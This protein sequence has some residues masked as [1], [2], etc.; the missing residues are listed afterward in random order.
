MGIDIFNQINNA[1]L[2][3][4]R[5]E[6]QTYHQ[7]IKR[8]ARLLESDELANA[9][10]RLLPKADFDEFLKS[11]QPQGGMLGSDSLDW[12]EDPEEILSLQLQM[13][14]RFGA[15][16]DYMR[17]FGHE[18]Y[19]SNR[20]VGSIRSITSQVIIPFARDFK[21]F[22]IN[23]FSTDGRLTLPTSN[24]V[25]VVHGHDEAALQG[26]AR[27]IEKI[28]LEAIVLKEQPNQGRTVIEKFEQASADVG[29]AVILLTP[30]DIGSKVTATEQDKRAR[31]NVIYELGYFTGKLGRGRVCLLMKGAV[32]IPSDL[33]GVIYTDLDPAEG[34]KQRLV[35][36]MKAA[37]LEFDANR[38]FL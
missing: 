12:P 31:Q 14:Q 34:W 36:E 16:P 10:S 28:G 38:V 15:N 27:F 21:E 35:K 11:Q 30:D 20:I 8:L 7:P 18:W 13:I 17:E 4:Q 5:S 24:K 22:S 23:G 2:D 25:F 3:L 9:R 37:K 33:N 1:I 32:E 29:F 19:Y 26:L 6:S